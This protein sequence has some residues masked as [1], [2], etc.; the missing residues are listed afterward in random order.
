VVPGRFFD[1]PSHIRIGFSGA[2]DRLEEGLARLGTA[3]DERHR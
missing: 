1:A 3:L 2:T